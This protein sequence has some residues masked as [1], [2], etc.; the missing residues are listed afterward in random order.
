[1]MDLTMYEH[2]YT[3]DLNQPLKWH[4]VGL[5]AAY[6][7]KANRF[8][9]KLTRGGADVDFG[10]CSVSGFFIRPSGDTVVFD[11]TAS[12]NLVYADL[13]EEC[14][15]FDGA[16]SLTIQIS[17][18]EFA[19]TVLICVGKIVQTRTS[20][21]APDD[22]DTPI[23]GAVFGEGFVVEGNKVSV[24]QEAIVQQVITALGTPVFGR[25]DSGNNII[26]SGELE[27]GTYTFKYETADGTTVVIGT[28]SS[29]GND[30]GGGSEEIDYT[31]AITRSVDVSGN[32]YN[33]GLGYKENYRYSASGGGDV[34][35]DGIDVTG[36]ISV[37]N[38]DVLYFQNVGMNKN[39]TNGNGCNMYIFES[40][41]DAEPGN[42][43]AA[44]M[45]NYNA[46]QWD[47][48]G[49]ITQLTVDFAG[50]VRFNTE[51]L[52]ADSVITINEPIV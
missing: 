46:A 25:V 47:A 7:K 45:T 49:Q 21:S 27:A 41:S 3:V 43:N 42:N 17:N 6:D 38:G 4:N 29:D 48:S 28:L 19:G 22:G 18:G 32:L 33:G 37:T 23:D 34:A 9:A 11:G 14:Y 50:Y 1:M 20:A 26:L 24:D 5:L 8:G 13:P 2:I 52:G 35:A 10:N 40:L 51:Y 12:G 16:F 36:Y 39:T 15:L 30:E 44:S 31:N